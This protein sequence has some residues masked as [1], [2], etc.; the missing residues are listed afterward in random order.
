MALITNPLHFYWEYWTGKKIKSALHMMSSSCSSAG[1]EDDFEMFLESVKARSLAA[2]TR[3]LESQGKLHND[4]VEFSSAHREITR[5]FLLSGSLDVNVDYLEKCFY[6]SG[7]QWMIHT[8]CV[9]CTDFVVGW[10]KFWCRNHLWIKSN[11]NRILQ[12]RYCKLAII[13]CV[14]ELLELCKAIIMVSHN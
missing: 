3:A 9:W 4:L 8:T 13:L 14:G 12:V 10:I 5:I 1:G 2:R 6:E 7:F 11:V